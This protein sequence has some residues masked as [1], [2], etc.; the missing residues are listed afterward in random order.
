MILVASCCKWCAIS[1]V[2]VWG[3]VVFLAAITVNA[4]LGSNYWGCPPMHTGSPS[5]APD[6]AGVCRQAKFFNWAQNFPP[7]LH[8]FFL[9]LQQ[10]F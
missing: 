7:G 5:L 4:S 1:L 2:S 3:T 8:I 9:N 6:G 10:N